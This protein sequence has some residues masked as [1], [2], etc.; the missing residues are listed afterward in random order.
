MACEPR[1]MFIHE[2]ASW[3]V[4]IIRHYVAQDY[5]NFAKQWPLLAGY[6]FDAYALPPT[7]YLLVLK[8][9]TEEIPSGPDA[10]IVLP[11][12]DHPS[13]PPSIADIEVWQQWCRS[14]LLLSNDQ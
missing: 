13:L 6:S 2:W 9:T 1:F 10:A 7:H 11:H 12:N 3:I 4:Q 14:R 8:S 5:P